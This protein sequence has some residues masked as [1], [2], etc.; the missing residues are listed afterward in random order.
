MTPEQGREIMRRVRLAMSGAVLVDLDPNLIRRMENQPRR[1]SSFDPLRM[2]RLA[3]SIKQSG[4]LM[5]GIIRRIPTDGGGRMYELCDGERRW[6]AVCMASVATYRALVIDV[7]DEA[8]QYVVSI[9]SNFNREGH[10]LPELLDSVWKQHDELSLTFEEIAHNVGLS[11]PYVSNIYHLKRLVPEVL[12]LLDPNLNKRPLATTVA[13]EISK[14][15][16]EHQLKLAQRVM[17]GELQTRLVSDEIR[18]NAQT[19]GAVT[20]VYSMAP[21][22]KRVSIQSRV[23]TLSKAASDLEKILRKSDSAVAMSEWGLGEL[24]NIQ[25][26]LQKSAQDLLASHEIVQKEMVKKQPKLIRAGR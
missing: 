19:Y 7:D 15:A 26:M 3:E 18:R 14:V 24:R 2:S 21:S 12:D 8:A 1:E 6:R 5:P 10:T 22:K 25:K 9:I 16:P 20:R 13:I 17:S 11:V 4:Q 23:T